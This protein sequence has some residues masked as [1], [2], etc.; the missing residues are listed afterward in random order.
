MSEQ[1]PI[2]SHTDNGGYR[3]NLW[4]TQGGIV[5]VSSGPH[6]GGIVAVEIPHAVI[7]ALIEA[8][9]KEQPEPEPGDPLLHTITPRGA[10][11]R[12]SLP[13]WDG[14][15]KWVARCGVCDKPVILEGDTDWVHAKEEAG[16]VS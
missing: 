4:S 11:L 12:M 16:N 15:E 7:P 9:A 13:G 6:P 1:K 5:A 10:Q 2:F 3:A 14:V 8:L